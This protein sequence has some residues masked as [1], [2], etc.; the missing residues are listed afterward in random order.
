[1]PYHFRSDEIPHY[2]Q[3]IMGFEIIE[4]GKSHLYNDRKS[5]EYMPKAEYAVL[6][7]HSDDSGAGTCAVGEGKM[8]CAADPPENPVDVHKQAKAMEKQKKRWNELKE[9]QDSLDKMIKNMKSKNR[10]KTWYE[11]VRSYFG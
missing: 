4:A 2:F 8:T 6:K 5:E 3:D 11:T 9:A 1:M 10:Q 7:V